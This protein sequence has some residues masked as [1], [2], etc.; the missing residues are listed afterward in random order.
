MNSS[1]NKLYR[2]IKDKALREKVISAKISEKFM[3]K[4]SKVKLGA[5]FV[6]AK[7]DIYTKKPV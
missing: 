5:N 4:L 2:A 3:F 1:E 6:E 7:Q